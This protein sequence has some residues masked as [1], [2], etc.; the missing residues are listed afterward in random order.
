MVVPAVPG[1]TDVRPPSWLAELLDDA[2]EALIPLTRFGQYLGDL[3]IEI[4][5]PESIEFLDIPPGPYRCKDSFT[6]TLPRPFIIRISR[7]KR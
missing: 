2:W 6:G 3:D 7:W 4:D 1:M 5:V